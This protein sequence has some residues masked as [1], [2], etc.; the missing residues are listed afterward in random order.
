[1]LFV[2]RLRPFIIPFIF[3]FIINVNS[4]KSFI[5]YAGSLVILFVVYNTVV[6]IFEW[7]NFTYFVSNNNIE[8]SDG[9]FIAKK[10]YITLNKIQSIQEDKK[11][12]HRMFGLTSLNIVTGTTVD[13]AFVKLDVLIPIEDE[14]LNKLLNII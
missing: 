13:N 14:E 4:L 2:N 8:I 10:R 11:L 7:R 9:R 1:I 12:L 3:I 6:S 5:I